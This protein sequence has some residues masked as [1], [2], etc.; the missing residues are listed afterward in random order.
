MHSTYLRFFIFFADENIDVTN[1]DVG[2]VI[3]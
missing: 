1:T 3:S 2:V